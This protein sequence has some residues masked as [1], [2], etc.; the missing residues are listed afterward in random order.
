MAA[1]VAATIVRRTS[2][3]RWQH[4]LER[5]YQSVK[6]V[7][8]GTSNANVCKGYL[9]LFQQLCEDVRE[10]LV[11]KV[12]QLG[13]PLSLFLPT[14][15]NVVSSIKDTEMQRMILSSIYQL[16]EEMPPALSSNLTKYFQTL[17]LLASSEDEVIRKV[18]SESL[19]LLAL[20]EH[21]D[22]VLNHFDAVVKLILNAMEDSDPAVAM[23]ATEFWSVF[24][25]SGGDASESM[26]TPY[27]E[28]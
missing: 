24:V 25:Y 28:Q 2:L 27:L 18:V 9:Y 12:E 7:E 4:L 6:G 16:I 21:S 26:I 22:I 19:V 13:R 8:E 23:A 15:L 20:S 5:I 1:V 11:D 14:M 17:F 3:K 10:E